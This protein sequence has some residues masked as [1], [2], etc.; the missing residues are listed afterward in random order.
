MIPQQ[1]NL[2]CYHCE[3]ERS[4]SFI[5]EARCYDKPLLWYSCDTCGIVRPLRENTSRIERFIDEELN[6]QNMRREE[7]W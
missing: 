1:I 5:D 3:S 4:F 6:A 2:Y 7:E